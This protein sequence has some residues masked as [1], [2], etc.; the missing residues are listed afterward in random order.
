MPCPVCCFVQTGDFGVEFQGGIEKDE[1]PTITCLKNPI[2]LSSSYGNMQEV[3]VCV[4]LSSPL[5]L[6]MCVSMSVPE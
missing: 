2:V 3:C 4:C 6:W 1:L 5:F